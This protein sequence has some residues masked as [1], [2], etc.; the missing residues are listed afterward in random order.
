M[1]SIPPQPIPADQPI[2]VVHAPEDAVWGLWIQQVCAG[3]GL[4]VRTRRLNG[5]DP[6]EPAGTV[7]LVVSVNF[8][9]A[10]G[11]SQQDWARL[12][13][14]AGVLAVL[15]GAADVP[16]DADRIPVVNLRVLPSAQQARARVL[17]ALGH[18]ASATVPETL[19][20]AGRLQVRYPREQVYPGYQSMTMPQYQADWFFGREQEMEDIRAR[21]DAENVVVLT[22]RPG[23]GK[24]WL[25][26]AYVHRFRSQYDLIAWIPGENGAVLRAELGKL[27]EP[28][29]L[30]DSLPRETLHLDVVQALRTLGKRYLIIYDNVTPDRYRAAGERFPLPRKP[31]RLSEVI[32]W[33]GP[34][35][36]LLTSKARDWDEPQPITVPRFSEQEGIDFL[37]RHVRALPDDLAKGLSAAVDGSPVLLNA[38]AHR[39]AGGADVI[40]ETFVRSVADKPFPV[41]ADGLYRQAALIFGGVVQPLIESP[42]GSDE[43]A[44]GRLLQLLTAFQEGQPIPLALLISQLPGTERRPGR[45]LP[46]PLRDALI[47]EHRRRNVL[48]LAT[49]DSVADVCRDPFTDRGQALKIHAV[50]WHGIRDYLG[51]PVVE[52]NRHVVHGML[53]DA[54]PQRTD[55]PAL[56]QRYLWLWQQLDCSEALTCRR[57]ADPQGTCAQLPALIQHV[58]DALGVQG[59]LTA[60]AGL[61]LRA[62]ESYSELLG[63]DHIGV[64]RI[65]VVTGNAL[66]QLGRSAEARDVAA[67]ARAGV[68]RQRERYPEEHVWSSDLLAACMRTAG[69]WAGAV[70]VNEESFRWARDHL[71]DSHIETIRAEHN[72]AVAYR[73]VG[74]FADAMDADVANYDRFRNDPLLASEAV[75]KLHCVNNVA[76]N[77]RE[78]GDVE[79]SVVLQEQVLRDFVELFENPRQ[80]HILRARKNLAVSYRKSGRYAQ[81]LE[82]QCAALADHVEVY[83]EEHPE[84]VAARTNV[85]ND[86]R[87]TGDLGAALRYAAEAYRICRAVRPDHPYTAAC[88]VNHAAALRALG[89]YDEALQADLEGVRI[90]LDRLGPDHPYTLA[91][92][93]DVASDL[94]GLGRP[95]EAA[96]LGADTLARLRR[97]RGGWHPYT[98]QCALNLSLDWRAQGRIEAADDLEQDTLEAYAAT[99]GPDHRESRAAAARMRGTCD[100]EPP[101]M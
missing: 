60:A 89:R 41:L 16:A 95:A 65:R 22:G 52:E 66:W 7:V 46:A 19:R 90:F 17:N 37:Q 54:D 98:L 18:T 50:P 64:V 6:A 20:Q 77:H 73:M 4:D 29:G 15:V 85:A 49:R 93:T 72:L 88:A 70:E 71:G 82:M 27:A 26:A 86:Y 38:L 96:E 1:A 14:R 3:V 24:T 87:M 74:R 57:V 67:A 5:T 62:A 55:L 48:T 100:V 61:G 59:E 44:A 45:R 40:D 8:V 83:G 34:G 21:L 12:A 99:L 84:S 2:V 47:T 31:A 81:A 69:D 92:Q 53:C 43:W 68:E 32:P 11:F 25:A 39:G 63:P 101:P 91:A 56:W 28:L 36:V 78:L 35:H 33:D 23:S 42:V 79:A 75:L 9:R 10:A 51:A 97:A 58:V 76:R 80:Q 30:P 13:D 94:A